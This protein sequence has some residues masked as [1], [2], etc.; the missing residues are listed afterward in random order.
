MELL[1]T[2]HVPDGDGPFPTIVALHGLGANAHD[3]L[4][5]A[6]ILHGGRALVLCPQAPLTLEVGPGMLG[7]GWFPMTR[8]GPPSPDAL[9]SAAKPLERFLDA[10]IERYPVRRDRL[11]LL[12]FS[13]GGVMAY[14]LFLEQPQRF[15]GL[16]A[17]SSW[18]PGALAE[19]YPA[20]DA[21]SDR[22]VLVMHGTRD[23]VID[24]ERARESR[25]TLLTR[26]HPL[27]YREY[28]MAHEIAPDALRDLR[29]WI[30]SKVFAPITLL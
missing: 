19:A 8:G 15:A 18:L 25:R 20:A 2:A 26:Q 3:L 11:L 1:Y 4:G 30:D 27:T 5:L 16:V 7:Y 12:G 9:E 6:P 28:E 14:R 21:P 22:P 13:Q 24:V 17:L 23:P 10:C 29:D